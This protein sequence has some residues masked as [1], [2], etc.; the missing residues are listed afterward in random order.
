MRFLVAE[1]LEVADIVESRLQNKFLA[2]ARRNNYTVQNG[3][4]VGKR[5]GVED[6]SAQRTTRWDV[7]TQRLDGKWIISHPEKKLSNNPNDL[8]EVMRNISLPIE[9][10]NSSWFPPVDGV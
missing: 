7:P 10:F 9:E 8:T 1:D 4:I 3:E 2:L 5:N 6:F